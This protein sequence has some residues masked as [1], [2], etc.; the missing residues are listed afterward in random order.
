MMLCTGSQHPNFINNPSS[1]SHYVDLSRRDPDLAP[2]RSDPRYEQAIRPF[3]RS[4]R[5]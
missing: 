5:K 3:R 4:G 2:L 1:V